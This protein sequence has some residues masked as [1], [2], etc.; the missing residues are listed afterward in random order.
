MAVKKKAAAG[1]EKKDA[2]FTFEQL[3]AAERFCNRRDMLKAVL[4]DKKKYSISVVEKKI[5]EFMKGKVR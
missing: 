1:E 5:E 3:L 2:V 4:S